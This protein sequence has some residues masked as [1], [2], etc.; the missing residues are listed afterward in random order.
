MRP[1][2]TSE[3]ILKAAQFLL[4]TIRK[5]NTDIT[6]PVAAAAATLFQPQINTFLGGGHALQFPNRAAWITAFDSDPECKLMIQMCQNP[7]L[8]KKNNLKNIHHVY[9]GP[10]RSFHILFEDGLLFLK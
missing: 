9:R 3:K 2:H 4:R 8:I 5:E 7:S 1:A 10:M 6:F